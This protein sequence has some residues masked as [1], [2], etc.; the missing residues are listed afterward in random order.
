MLFPRLAREVFGTPLQSPAC[1][2]ETSILWEV[3][4]FPRDSVQDSTPW[5]HAAI[6]TVLNTLAWGLFLRDHP[7]NIVRDCL[8]SFVS[9]FSSN[10]RYRA[11]IRNPSKY[12]VACSKAVWSVSEETNARPG[13]RKLIVTKLP[14]YDASASVSGKGRRYCIVS[15]YPCI[16]N[17][18]EKTACFP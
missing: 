2:G 12:P 13:T 8:F 1:R 6:A 4:R 9:V 3:I 7:W 15:R 16:M 10:P 17:C 14:E 11:P 18:R 5:S